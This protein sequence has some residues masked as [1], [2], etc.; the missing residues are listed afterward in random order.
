MLNYPNIC[1]SKLTVIIINSLSNCKFKYIYSNSV[2]GNTNFS[3]YKCVQIIFAIWTQSLGTCIKKPWHNVVCGFSINQASSTVVNKPAGNNLPIC[4]LLTEILLPVPVEMS[5]NITITEIL[6]FVCPAPV[7][8]LSLPGYIE[9]LALNIHDGFRLRQ[10]ISH[11]K[12]NP[13]VKLTCKK[14]TH[15]TAKS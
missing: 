15:F 6:S 8:I 12:L 1:Q 7:W 4:Q 11:F 3:P 5:F 2:F 13:M 9:H 14:T 10:G